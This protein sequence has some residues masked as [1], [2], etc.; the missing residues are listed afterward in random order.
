MQ[1][2][3]GRELGREGE[4]RALEPNGFHLPNVNRVHCQSFFLWL[5]LDLD[6]SL[7]FDLISIYHRSDVA[8]DMECFSIHLIFLILL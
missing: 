2:W 3:R 7:W 8:I 4:N 1:D 6:L 5:L